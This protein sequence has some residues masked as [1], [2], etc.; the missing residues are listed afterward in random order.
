MTSTMPSLVVGSL[1][2]QWPLRFRDRLRVAEVVLVT[3]TERLGIGWWH[4]LHIMTEC[5]QLAGHIMR[6]HAGLDTN[7]ALR[8]DRKPRCD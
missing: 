5:N 4:L 7:Q 3:L 6:R 1:L 2:W 8:H